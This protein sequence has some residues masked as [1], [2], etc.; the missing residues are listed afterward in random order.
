MSWCETCERFEFRNHQC[1][2][3]WLVWSVDDGETIDDARTEFADDAVE[4]A[5]RMAEHECEG[6]PDYYSTYESGGRT[7]M[8]REA[9]G[10]DA[11][12]VHVDGETTMIYNGTVVGG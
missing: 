10:G 2:P 12:R 1:P 8:V 9:D 3:R 4:A 6:D 11:V 7:F 5:E